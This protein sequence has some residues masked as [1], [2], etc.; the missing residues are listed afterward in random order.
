MPVWQR[1]TLGMIMAAALVSAPLVHADSAPEAAQEHL[2]HLTE[3]LAS[4]DHDDFIRNGNDAF[5]S[6][7]S[8]RMFESVQEH[9]GNR[10]AQGFETTYLSTIHQYGM[11]VHVWSIHFDDNDGDLIARLAVDPNGDIGGIWFH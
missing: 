1:T 8:E 10:F 9:L 7:L 3:T 6:N 2:A 11:E 5:K 4:G